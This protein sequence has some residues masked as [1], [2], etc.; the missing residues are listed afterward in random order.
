MKMQPSQSFFIPGF[1]QLHHRRHQRAKTFRGACHG[2]PGAALYIV[3]LILADVSYTLADPP[4][5]IQ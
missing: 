1:E 5:S 3:G 2:V 4:R